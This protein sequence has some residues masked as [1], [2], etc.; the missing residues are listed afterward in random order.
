MIAPIQLQCIFSY[1]ILANPEMKPDAPNTYQ[2]GLVPSCSINSIK[3]EGSTSRPL[4]TIQF[5]W[6]K[7][8]GT[9]F[10]GEQ[11]ASKLQQLWQKMAIT[12]HNIL[13]SKTDIIYLV[14]SSV[15]LLAI[16]LL[17]CLYQDS[18]PR[19]IKTQVNQAAVELQSLSNQH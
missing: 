1:T 3:Y 2:S 8:F 13:K 6:R 19:E 17:V 9:T 7:N 11:P 18:C 14:T 12:H 10:W 4:I 15:I 16:Q 5:Q